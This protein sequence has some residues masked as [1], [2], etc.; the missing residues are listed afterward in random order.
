MQIIELIAGCA[1]TAMFW[2]STNAI[3]AISLMIVLF[4]NNIGHSRRFK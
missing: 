3:A 4:A 1:G 2:Y